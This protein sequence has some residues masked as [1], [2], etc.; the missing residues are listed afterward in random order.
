MSRRERIKE[1]K[2]GQLGVLYVILRSL[3]LILWGKGEQGCDICALEENPEVC[4]ASTG[5]AGICGRYDVGDVAALIR[6]AVVTSRC[7]V[8]V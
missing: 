1:S 4:I 6:V 2:W 8:W 3:I 7:W 5:E